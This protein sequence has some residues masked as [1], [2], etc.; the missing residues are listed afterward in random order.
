VCVCSVDSERIRKVVVE[1]LVHVARHV[2]QEAEGGGGWEGGVAGGEGWG[3]GEW[4]WQVDSNTSRF[5]RS[6]RFEWYQTQ[7]GSGS[8]GRVAVV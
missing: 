3:G 2:E 6:A 1:R 7:C 5:V 4:Q 8:I